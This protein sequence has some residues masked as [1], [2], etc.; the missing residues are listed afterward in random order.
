MT[1]AVH[2]A[3]FDLH[4]ALAH[5]G[6]GQAV[7]GAGQQKTPGTIQQSDG[8][9]F[10]AHGFG[11]F[12]GDFM[13]H[14]LGFEAGADHKHHI[15]QGAEIILGHG[16]Y[17]FAPERRVRTDAVSR[18]AVYFCRSRNLIYG[19]QYAPNTGRAQ[20]VSGPPGGKSPP[21]SGHVTPAPA[22]RGPSMRIPRREAVR[23]SPPDSR[24]V[25]GARRSGGD[26]RGGG[27][28][29]RAF[30]LQTCSRLPP[31]AAEPECRPRATLPDRR[32]RS[33]PS[34]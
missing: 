8:A 30:S 29:A 33:G 23:T 16:I 1:F 12:L 4:G 18:A 25:F 19:L 7:G 21:F 9:G 5:V 17:S 10:A 31:S 20:A 2:A 27:P 26:G 3:T 32:R 15:A 34:S 14:L 11:G 6:G 13:Q 24:R 28:P 22:V